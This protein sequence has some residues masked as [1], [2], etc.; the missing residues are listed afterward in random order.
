MMSLWLVLSRFSYWIAGGFY[1]TGFHIVNIVL[2][3]LVSVTFLLFV[4][5]ILCD[6]QSFGSDGRFLFPQPR[7]SLLAAVLFAV[8]PVHTESVRIVNYYHLH[9]SD[10]LHFFRLSF[11]SLYAR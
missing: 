1:P 6:G 9:G 11:L 8:H 10:G 5:L 2:H 7:T 4:S 3:G